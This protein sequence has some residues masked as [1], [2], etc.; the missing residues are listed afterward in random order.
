[1]IKH[2][3]KTINIHKQSIVA[4]CLLSLSISPVCKA[5]EVVEPVEQTDQC[6][7][8]NSDVGLVTPSMPLPFLI[9]KTFSPVVGADLLISGLHIYMA[10]DDSLLPSSVGDTSF[11]MVMGRLGK[12]A[13]EDILFAWGMVA[14]HEFFGHGAR[15]REFHVKNNRYQILPY[16]GWTAPGYGYFGLSLTEKIAVTAGGVEANYIAARELRTQ[17]LEKNCIDEREGHF[18]FWNIMAQTQYV[19]GTRNRRF[20]G[21]EL[22]PDGGHDIFTYVREVNEWYGRRVLTTANLRRKILMDFLDPYLFYSLYAMG[23]YLVDGTQAMEYPMIPIGPYRYLPGFRI[24]LAPYGPEYQFINYIQGCDQVIQATFRYGNI[25]HRQTYGLT[26]DVRELWTSD[27]LAID[28]RLDIWRQPRLYTYR[29]PYNF[30]KMGGA[31]S[32]FARYRVNQC[33][34]VMGQIG[35]KTTGF[36]QGEELKHTPILRVG[37]AINM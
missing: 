27:K 18:Y 10:L 33:L 7:T 19:L 22:E 25:S 26:L 15:L 20:H 3:L 14:Q 31:A 30:D 4:V 24:A 37:I 9:D 2:L 23:H 8:D 6:V 32:L 35:Y 28:G 12:F 36:M 34:E 1:M 13:L 21:W 29:A 17:W 16:T 5:D 11:S